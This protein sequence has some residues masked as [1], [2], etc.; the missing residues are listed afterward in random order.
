MLWVWPVCTDVD[1]GL[2]TTTIAG[3]VVVV[4]VS[5]AA[6]VFVVSA[7]DFAVSVTV[8]GFGTLAGAAYVIAVPEA[9]VDVDRVPQVAP[10]HPAPLK[11]QV[12][13][14]FCES[15]CT[16]AVMLR[17]C[18]VCTDAD[19]GFTTTEMAGGAEAVTV[20]VVAA[21]FV[22]SA[23]DFAVSVTV[24]GFG[25]PAGAV[26][27]IAVPE[28]LVDVDNVPQVA[29]LHPAP[30]K[31]QVTPLFCESFCTVAVTVCVCPVCTD[32]DV[33]FTA[34]EMAGGVAVVTVIVVA[35]VLVVSATD[36]AVSVTVAGLGTLAG[37]VYVM[38]VPEALAFADKMPQA[39]PLHPL[40]LK[41]QVTPLFCVSFCKVAAMLCV[42]PVCTE[43]V[44]GLT[45][46]EIA[47]L[48]DAVI[49][50]VAAAD[51]VP[52]V[53]DVAVAVTIAGLGTAA[54]AVYVTATLEPLVEVDSVPHVVPLH[55]APD[56]VQLRP[57]F[58]E[59]F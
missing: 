27:V 17:G 15:F 29:P 24:A 30:P 2:T 47:A 49:V 8:A 23:T 53:T 7:T 1:V 34:T 38:A 5:V 32:A 22:V 41:F 39:A 13:P 9:L 37:A 19:V 59:S 14:L 26:Y 21:V 35:A 36:L 45:V 52:S 20:I 12:T 28:A 54:G 25:T 11:V 10:L 4:I 57:L 18:P 56:N 40:P 46:T 33:G 42:F 55:P 51:F 6:A 16:V 43:N 31:V 3:G 58:C 48:E 50:R 44:V